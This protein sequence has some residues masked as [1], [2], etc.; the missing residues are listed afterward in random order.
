MHAAIT[1]F[2]VIC[3]TARVRNYAVGVINRLH[4]ESIVDLSISCVCAALSTKRQIFVWLIRFFVAR[5]RFSLFISF[6]AGGTN[7]RGV[8]GSFLA[9]LAMSFFCHQTHLNK[10]QPDN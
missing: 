8:S 2:T 9:G 6:G 5:L 10:E 1:V 4:L 7:S 3:R